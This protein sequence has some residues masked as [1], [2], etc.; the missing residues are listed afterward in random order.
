MRHTVEVTA[1]EKSGNEVMQPSAA[2]R[3]LYL[4]Y[5]ELRSGQ[6]SYSYVTDTAMFIK[7]LDLYVQLRRD[8]DCALAPEVTFDDGHLSNHDLAAPLLEERGLRGIFFITAGWTD[9]RPGYMGWDELRSLVQAGHTIGGHGWSHK[10]LTH[11]DDNALRHELR[12][13]RLTLEDGLGVGV[14]TMS[15]PGGRSN[16]RVLAACADAGYEHVFTSVP[17][18]ESVPLGATVGRLNIRGNMQTDWL[19]RLFAP[20]GNLLSDLAR[21]SKRKEAVKKLLGDAL[22]FKLWALVNRQEREEEA[23]E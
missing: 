4:L 8:K 10:L 5:H 7:H 20:D 1:I 18:A 6:S 3:R 15:L 11:C 16:R 9:D 23:P 21:Q 22:Y 14:K 17:Q 13:T 2:T 12:D 19:A